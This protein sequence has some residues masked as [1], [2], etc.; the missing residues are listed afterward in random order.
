M[1]YLFVGNRG[2]R[3]RLHAHRERVAPGH[4]MRITTEDIVHHDMGLLAASNQ[5]FGASFVVFLDGA[6]QEREVREQVLEHAKAMANSENHFFV[7]ENALDAVSLKKLQRHAIHED[8]ATEAVSKGRQEGFFSIADA[9]GSRDRK[10]LW[11]EI[12]SAL[13]QGAVPEE[14]HGILWW[15]VKNM[16]LVKSA[17]SAADA[18]INPFVYRKASSFARNYAPAE[19]ERLA[20]TVANLL[21]FARRRGIDSAHALEQ[22]ALTLTARSR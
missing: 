15:G 17:R 16:L 9:L 5:L 19:L 1:I 2:T 20:E 22:F 13:Y 6:L 4:I 7:L 3:E 11:V 10:K 21:F 8:V 12:V 18:G 14:I